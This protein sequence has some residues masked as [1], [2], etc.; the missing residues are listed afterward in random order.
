MKSFVVGVVVADGVEMRR[1]MFSCFGS[2][3]MAVNTCFHRSKVKQ[4]IS[5]NDRNTTVV[6][7][8]D[9]SKDEDDEDEDEETKGE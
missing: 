3:S 7:A 5:E 8:T 6:D 2:Q 4:S 9:A 1:F